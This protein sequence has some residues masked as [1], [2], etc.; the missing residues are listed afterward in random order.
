MTLNSTDMGGNGIIAEAASTTITTT[1]IDT[2]TTGI[3]VDFA[4]TAPSW[5][6]IVLVVCFV[7]FALTVV[8]VCFLR[9]KAELIRKAPEGEEN[10]LADQ[11]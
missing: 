9:K 4:S 3:A 10:L 8:N 2:N 1:S 6:W 11:S 5:L 7:V